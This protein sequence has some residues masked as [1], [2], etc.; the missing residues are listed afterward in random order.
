MKQ[1]LAI[2][3]PVTSGVSP[4][5]RKEKGTF[6]CAQPRMFS[7]VV[8]T[9]TRPTSK[10]ASM[11]CTRVQSDPLLSC[12]GRRLSH[13]QGQSKA[14][15]Q[16]REGMSRRCGRALTEALPLAVVDRAFLVTTWCRICQDS[17]GLRAARCCLV[18][19]GVVRSRGC[20]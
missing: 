1:G 4:N 11:V 19:F 7:L 16:K 17:W 12:T 2:T 14:G 3:F 10:M 20:M 9:L 5:M 6:C 18:L 8:A 13:S 15:L